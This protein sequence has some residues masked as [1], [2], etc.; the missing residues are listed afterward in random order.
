MTRK[1]Q[2]LLTALLLTVGVTSAWAD[3]YD[4]TSPVYNATL[5]TNCANLKA[6]L[7]GITA[8]TSE[9]PKT[10]NIYVYGNATLGTG[11][12]SRFGVEVDYVTV[13][14]I[15]Q[16]DVTITRGSH[17][18]GNIWF[19]VNKSHSTLNIGNAS[20]KLT[21]DDDGSTNIVK[22]VLCR[23][24]G[25]MTVTNV[26]FSDIVFN[27]T[28]GNTSE[29]GYLYSDKTTAGS[30]VVMT[31]ITVTN[32]TTT[33]DAFIYSQST[34]DNNIVLNGTISFSGCTGK[35]IESAKKIAILGSG[36]AGYKAFSASSPLRIKWDGST[37]NGTTV[38]EGVAADDNWKGYFSLAST[39]KALT[40]N[41][42]NLQVADA[43]VL[44]TTQGTGFASLNDAV[45]QVN[46]DDV[47]QLKSDITLSSNLSTSTG[48]KGFTLQANGDADVVTMANGVTLTVNNSR[49][50][51]DGITFKV[52]SGKSATITRGT[53]DG[54]QTGVIFFVNS[55]KTLTIDGTGGTLTLQDQS[56]AGAKL[57]FLEAN[58]GATI[59][60]TNVTV[61]GSAMSQSAPLQAKS[62]GTMTLTNVT[63]E[64][65]SAALGGVW[66]RGNVTL[67][68]TIVFKNIG[69]GKPYMS[70]ANTSTFTLTD[71]TGYSDGTSA[72][73][74][75]PVRITGDN[76]DAKLNE[77]T[78]SDGTA[79]I[80]GNTSA[81]Y[82]IT[83]NKWYT[84]VSG[85]DIYASTSY[86]L[87]VT[88]AGMSTLVL[89]FN[90][91]IPTQNTDEESKTV[92]AYKLTTA[93]SVVSAAS[94]DAIAAGEPVLIVADAG[95]YKFEAADAAITYS[96]DDAP[97]SGALVGAYKTT[98]ADDGN[99]VLQNG[100]EG[101]GFYKLVAA[102][103]HVINPF[104]AY[105]S[106]AENAA[107]R[108]AIVFD[109]EDVTGIETVDHEPSTEN[110]QYYDLSGR[111]VAQP[112]KGLYIVNGRKVVIR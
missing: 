18:R 11:A 10:Y 101:V 16:V 98:N 84:Y 72:I 51:L 69:S 75:I 25:N 17:T 104:R 110:Q 85:S 13:N 90:A 43:T 31:D 8:G 48:D 74:T 15:P 1:L 66:S 19:L 87:T 111:K 53:G 106:S 36:E 58:N 41:S 94:V 49:I 81:N 67:S 103:N 50:T 65:I 45:A 70:V 83:N 22:S 63:F 24:A 21:I 78:R 27:Y 105:L 2:F 77:I 80:I 88:A 71:F 86:T 38:V 26:T 109:D 112:T 107:A 9:S 33:R 92:S 79:L 57:S 73:T 20:K 89:P 39:T 47:L 60:L 56:N 54:G 5:G 99:Y 97:Q 37:D 46:K 4:G 28:E 6:A 68:G 100:A 91:T 3:D 55:G 29:I 42:A 34:T 40:R 52:A 12:N 102:S 96:R 82:N 32:C 35:E 76:N 64:D 108:L 7:T 62:G 30:K 95:S 23:E 44:N 14:L 93:S 61:K 59:N